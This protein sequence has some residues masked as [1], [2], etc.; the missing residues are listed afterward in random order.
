MTYRIQEIVF[1]SFLLAVGIGLYYHT[2]DTS[3]GNLAQD[4]TIG[5]MFFPKILLIVW[6]FCTSIML[7]GAF[8]RFHAATPFEWGKVLTAVGVLVLFALCF[9]SAG[10]YITGIGSFIGLSVVLGYRKFKILIPVSIA[11]IMLVDV[12]FRYLLKSYLPTCSLL[13]V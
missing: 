11:Y 6:I 7:W 9:S 13:G 3:Y 10:F 4:I 8:R 12:V 2:F 1:N 5:P